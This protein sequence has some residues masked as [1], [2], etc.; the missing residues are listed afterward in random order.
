MWAAGADGCRAGWICVRRRDGRGEVE[1]ALHETAAEL[2]GQRPAPGVL[3]IDIPIGLTES[4]PRECDREARHALGPKRGSSVFPA[5]IRAVL[6]AATW[7]EACALRERAEGKRMSKQAWFIVAK[8]REVDEALAGRSARKKPRVREVHPE[9]SFQTWKGAP[10]RHGK[11]TR[12]GR[13]ERQRLVA[14]E[15]GRHAF[16]R[17]REAYGVSQVAHDDI[18]DAFAVLWTAERILRRDAVVRPATPPRDA[19]G[20]AMEIVT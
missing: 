9:L 1:H 15:F 20:L 10:L 2:V 5:P 6:R 7:E 11:R 4:G 12:L 13:R 16:E 3:G 17:V 8:I 19:R 14:A 18:L